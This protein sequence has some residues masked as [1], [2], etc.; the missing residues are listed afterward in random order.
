VSAF[1]SRGYFSRHFWSWLVR[2]LMCPAKNALGHKAIAQALAGAVKASSRIGELLGETDNTG[3][4]I[5]VASE[6]DR[7]AWHHAETAVSLS[8]TAEALVDNA[9]LRSAPLRRSRSRQ[10]QGSTW[11]EHAGLP[12]SS[13][14]APGGK[15]KTADVR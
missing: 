15:G 10:S 3:P 1:A 8:E 7:Q 13:D 14:A 4:H 6:L 9:Q 2:D 5:L 12:A 11:G